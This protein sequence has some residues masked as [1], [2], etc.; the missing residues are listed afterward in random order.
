[1]SFGVFA[2][3]HILTWNH[4]KSPNSFEVNYRRLKLTDNDKAI[5][6]I[7]AGL[8]AGAA[9]LV[10]N[11]SRATLILIVVG[12]SLTTLYAAKG[13]FKW[14]LM[15]EDD[16]KRFQEESS[17]NSQNSPAGSSRTVDEPG[18]ATPGSTHK[19]E[20]FRQK[21]DWLIPQGN[22]D[23]SFLGAATHLRR[24]NERAYFGSLW[25]KIYEGASFSHWFNYSVQDGLLKNNKFAI[26]KDAPWEDFARFAQKHLQ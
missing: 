21:P 23:P 9:P 10:L 4:V 17:R 1:M 14:R 15:I 24:E 16:Q 5:A 19:I 2:R 20:D 7:F 25:K 12:T 6:M 26:E 13:Y 8:A 3:E 22:S 18:L 11:R